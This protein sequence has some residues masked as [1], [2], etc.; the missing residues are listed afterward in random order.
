M[1]ENHHADS[2]LES[3]RL[4]KLGTGLVTDSFGEARYVLQFTTFVLQSLTPW[5][6]QMDG[7]SREYQRVSCLRSKTIADL[8]CSFSIDRLGDEDYKPVGVTPE[9]EVKRRVLKGDPN[10]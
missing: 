7:R 3:T 2:R 4:R 9:P 6:S 8:V 5:A 1:T 10:S